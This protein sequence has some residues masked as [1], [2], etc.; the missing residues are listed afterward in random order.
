MA[1]KADVEPLGVQRITLS[2]SRFQTLPRV[3][4]IE[5]AVIEKRKKERKFVILTLRYQNASAVPDL[6]VPYVYRD[7]TKDLE[8]FNAVLTALPD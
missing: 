5:Y 1:A 3:L 7:V 8:G 4:Q 2:D 6:L